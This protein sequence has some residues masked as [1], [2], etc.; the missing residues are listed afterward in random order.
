MAE[1]IT[2]Q[3]EFLPTAGGPIRVLDAGEGANLAEALRKLGGSAAAGQFGHY[4]LAV[5]A[6]L[7]HGFAP[8]VGDWAADVEGAH[9]TWHAAKADFLA[10]DPW[11]GG[12]G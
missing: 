11:G 2:A 4:R 7:D 10:A 8:I 5:V 6:R 9:D 1:R 3:L 12:P